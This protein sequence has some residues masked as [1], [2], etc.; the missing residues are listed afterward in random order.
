MASKRQRGHNEERRVLPLSSRR[1]VDALNSHVEKEKSDRYQL[2]TFDESFHD[3]IPFEQ[4]LEYNDGIP[5]EQSQVEAI[6]L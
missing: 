5:L 6:N 2:Q 4:S 3:E 1:N